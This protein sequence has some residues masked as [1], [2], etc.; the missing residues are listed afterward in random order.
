[1]QR[2]F[3]LTILVMLGLGIAIPA[4]AEDGC[5]AWWAQVD[6]HYAGYREPGPV[7]LSNKS[8]L[9][10]AECLLKLE[11][12]KSPARFSGATHDYVSQIFPQATVELAAL[13]YIEYLF[14]GKFDHANGV[15][16]R[17]KKPPGGVNPPGCMNTA[18]KAYR[19]WLKYVRASGVGKIRSEKRH[20]LDGTDIYWY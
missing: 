7:Y 11:G 18:Y 3:L 16:F 9:D 1:M 15:A 19:T 13:Y 5:E 12:N 4:I 20:A 6:P 2:A 14:V 8:F 10:G 17:S